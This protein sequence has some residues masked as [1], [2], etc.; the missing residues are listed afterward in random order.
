MRAKTTISER[1][2]CALMGL[3]RTV[4]RYTARTECRNDQLR[5]RICEL[6]SERRRFGYRRIHALLRREGTSVNVKRVHRLYCQERL[7][8]RRRRKRH[9]VAVERR[10]LLMPQGPNQTWSIDFVSDALEHGRRLKCLTIVMTSPR[11]PSTSWSI[12]ESPADTSRV[13]W[14]RSDSFARYRE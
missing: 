13:C 9:G 2:A 8:V 3:S 6:A 1:R 4:M 5:A 11:S 12:M 14:T 10:P 7:Q